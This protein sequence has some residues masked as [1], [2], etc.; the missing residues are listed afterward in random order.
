MK[1]LAQQYQLSRLAS[2]CDKSQPIPVS[3]LSNDFKTLLFGIII[4]IFFFTLFLNLC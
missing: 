1:E 3:T 2:I 4:M